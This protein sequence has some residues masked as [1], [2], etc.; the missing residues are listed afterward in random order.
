[1]SSSLLYSNAGPRTDITIHGLSLRSH[2]VAPIAFI[3]ADRNINCI[4]ITS[5]VTIDCATFYSG[6]NLTTPYFIHPVESVAYSTAD[7]N[8]DC[9]IITSIVT[10]DCATFDS[11]HNSP[12]SYFYC[13]QSWGHLPTSTLSISVANW[14]QVPD[15]QIIRLAG[16][17]FNSQRRHSGKRVVIGGFNSQPQHNR[18]RVQ[19]SVASCGFNS[20]PQYF[21]SRVQLPATPNLRDVGR[22][23][24]SQRLQV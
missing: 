4:I 14:V 1:V 16:R 2:P 3:K 19:L 8:V 24:D 22:G 11:G 9:I 5:I 18:P 15:Q 10:I 12:T 6:N 13:H 20:Q 23:F 17:E 21:R 7:R